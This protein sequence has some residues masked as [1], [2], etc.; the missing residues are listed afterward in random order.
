MSDQ[1][2]EADFQ[3]IRNWMRIHVGQDLGEDKQY[4]VKVAL[5][6]IQARYQLPTISHCVRRL[7]S[8]APSSA[9][10]NFQAI[11]DSGSASGRFV[12]DTVDALMIGETYFFRRPSTFDDLRQFVL[13]TLIEKRQAKKRLRIWSAACS[14]GQEPYSLAMTL[15]DYFPDVFRTW[16]LLIIATDISQKAID[17][18]RSGTFSEWEIGRGLDPARRDR[19]FTRQGSHWV[20]QNEIK[21]PIRFS[22]CN[23]VDPQMNIPFRP[24]DLILLRNVLIYFDMQKKKEILGK[25]RDHLLDDGYLLLG[26]SETLLG[27][28]EHFQI[29]NH[30]PALCEPKGLGSF[31]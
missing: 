7:E 1:L 10:F 20:A 12:Q 27:L 21:S 9:M 16:D 25:V 28:E 31:R 24:F 23:L 13:P 5:A 3:F 18:S 17:K 29:S 30:A 15:A 26:E 2:S 8:L 14:T 4:L 11:L 19:Y 22:R 6:D